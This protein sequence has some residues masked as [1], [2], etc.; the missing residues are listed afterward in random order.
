MMKYII[1]L[2]IIFIFKFIIYIGYSFGG[3]KVLICTVGKKENK[4]IKEFVEHYQKLKVKKIVIYDNNDINGENFKEVLKKEINSHFIKLINY[5]GI[6]SPQTQA[7]NNCYQKYN[8]LFDWVAFYDIDEFLYIKNYSNLNDFLSLPQ[9]KKC[10]SILINWKYFGDNEKLYYEEKPLNERFIDPINITNNLK[11]IND[12]YFNSAA[13]S[14]VRS[15]LKLNWGLLPHFIN[16]TI[17]C[18][19]NGSVLNDYFSPYHHSTAYLKHYLTKSTEEFIERLK[20]GDVL[21][22][23]TNFY[24]I[25]RI[26]NYYFLFNKKTNEKLKLFKK[27]FKNIIGF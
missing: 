15:G 7:L 19:P 11:I 25:N 20:R 4:Y 23:V 26:Y 10:E 3:L 13:K 12:K 24:I 17:N 18:R 1:K 22:N 21:V 5:R 2:K 16:N 8:H 27:K 6:K 9:F 14:I